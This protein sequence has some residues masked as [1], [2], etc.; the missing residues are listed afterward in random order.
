MA[1]RQFQCTNTGFCKKA[2]S[3]EIISSSAVGQ[4]FCPECGKEL[5]A[6][7]MGGNASKGGLPLGRIAAGVGAVALL[8][9]LAFLVPRFLGFG[10]G[11]PTP[12]PS[13]ATTASAPSAPSPSSNAAASPG[14]NDFD[15]PTVTGEAP[16]LNSNVFFVYEKSLQKWLEPIQS[17]INQKSAGQ[18]ELKMDYRGS[19]DGF[20]EI[21]Y[22][23]SKPVL[24][25]PADT[26]WTERLRQ[27][28]RD[29][30]YGGNS[31]DILPDAPTVIVTSRLVLVMR[32]DKARVFEVTARRPEYRNRTWKLLRDLATKGWGDL[33]GEPSWGKLRL[34]HSNPLES[35]SGTQTIALI[36]AEY[37]R[38]NPGATPASPGFLA[39]MGDIERSVVKFQDTT[40]N[41][42]KDL[43][44]NKADIAI[45]YEQNALAKVDEGE[46]LQFIYPSPTVLIRF[47]AVV[48]NAPWVTPAQAKD[49]QKVI[50]YLLTPD[51]QKQLITK[52]FRPSRNDLR[53]DIDRELNTGKRADAG[54]QIS[55]NAVESAADVQAINDLQFRWNQLFGK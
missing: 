16:S 45:A 43:T 4:V 22:G 34:A 13:P 37:R 53:A 12:S 36:F 14:G 38:D 17:G 18:G 21:L 10:G 23:K 31:S 15:A 28:W 1:Y 32:P 52:G 26:Y 47:P 49:G 55:P 51:V 8:A 35:N 20:Q 39:F 6:L 30:K 41:V 25:N 50:D 11:A 19:R 54:F 3:R 33:G 5:T 44:G 42:L 9:G 48:L 29:P 27:S 24:W 2:D 46:N 40:S 7:D